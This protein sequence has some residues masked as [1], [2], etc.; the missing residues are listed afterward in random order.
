MPT[1]EK[2]EE[3]FFDFCRRHDAWAFSCM[4]I[5]DSGDVY[6]ALENRLEREF[7]LFSIEHTI[8]HEIGHLFHY[9][10]GIKINS[11]ADIGHETLSD[12]IFI[13]LSLMSSKTPFLNPLLKRFIIHA[14]AYMSESVS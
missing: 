2:N 5:S 8:F 4:P 1:G 3:E 6:L 10:N 9:G 7:S 14:F 13:L 12:I 11:S